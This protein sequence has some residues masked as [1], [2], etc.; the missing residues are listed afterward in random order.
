MIGQNKPKHNSN[1]ALIAIQDGI[2][3]A[4]TLINPMDA[5]LVLLNHQMG[6]LQTV[7]DISITELRANTTMLAKLATLMNL[8]VITTASVLDGPLVPEVHHAAPHACHVPLKA[9]LNAL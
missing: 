7:K 8:P 2:S 3:Q 6:L 4:S 9:E 1:S 5:A